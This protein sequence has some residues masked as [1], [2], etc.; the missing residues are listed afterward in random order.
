M[1]FVLSS[2]FIALSCSLAQYEG[3]ENITCKEAPELI[4]KLEKDSSF[5]ILDLRPESMFKEGHL[6]NAKFHDVFADDFENWLKD[7]DKNQT[8]LLYCNR[9]HRSGIAMEKMKEMG[10][11][12]LYHLYEG[13]REW[14]KQGLPVIKAS[15]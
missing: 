2:L 3:P 4:Q 10:F 7:L 8:Y 5:V 12:N 9:G 15:K 11:K 1:I 14:K 6:E 13:I